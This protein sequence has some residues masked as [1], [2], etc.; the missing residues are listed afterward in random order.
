MVEL[1]LV[2]PVHNEADTIVSFVRRVRET[3]KVLNVSFEIICVENGSTDQS[4]ELLTGVSGRLKDVRVIRSKLGWGNAVRQGLKHANGRLFCYM[5]SDGQ[6]DP[7]CLPALYRRLKEERVAL[8]K[9]LRTTRENSVRSHLSRA[10][11]VIACRLF[12]F[13][14]RDIN[15]T[16]KMLRTDLARQLKLSEKNIGIDLELLIRLN[17]RALRWVEIPIGSGKRTAGTSTTKIHSVW[18]MLRVM[19]SLVFRLH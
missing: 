17:Q 6:I 10:Y 12:G 2:L 16:P 11:N 7:K 8:V 14:S 5:V 1:T 19:S 15:A 9:V 18:E 13:A 3:L 4:Y